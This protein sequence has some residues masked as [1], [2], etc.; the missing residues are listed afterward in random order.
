MVESLPI[1]YDVRS[2]SDLLWPRSLFR[3][4]LDTEL[5][6]LLTCLDVELEAP[7]IPTKTLPIHLAEAR[8]KLQQ[9]TQRLWHLYPEA[10]QDPETHEK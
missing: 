9:F 7:F 5:I 8:Q 1:V 3:S 4:V 6:P 2:C 10:F